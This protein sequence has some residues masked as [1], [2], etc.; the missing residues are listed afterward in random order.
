[1]VTVS[2]RTGKVHSYS[3]LGDLEWSFDLGQKPT[4]D[5][6]MDG[7]GNVYLATGA[8]LLCLDATGKKKWGPVRFEAASGLAIGRGGALVVLT[9][10]G[11]SVA[12]FR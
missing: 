4:C 8:E 7:A 12:C 11:Q 1:M 9:D 2:D 5:P 10:G 3:L 6:V